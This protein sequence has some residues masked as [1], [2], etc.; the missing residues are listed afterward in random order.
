[1]E[2]EIF[3][4]YCGGHIVRNRLCENPHKHNGHGL[5]KHLQTDVNAH[6]GKETVGI[7][8]LSYAH[9][10]VVEQEY[11]GYGAYHEKQPQNNLRQ[12]A[13]MHSG[14]HEYKGVIPK[15]HT[16]GG[17]YGEHTEGEASEEPYHG[18]NELR[19]NVLTYANRQGEHKIALRAQQILVKSDDYDNEGRHRKSE[20][21]KEIGGGQAEGGK[22]R[23]AA[24]EFLRNKAHRIAQ[25]GNKYEHGI[26]GQKVNRR[27]AKFVFHQFTEHL[28]TSL[29]TPSRDFPLCSRI[30]SQLSKM[31]ISPF[32]RK[33]ASSR[34]FSM[35]LIRWVEMTTTAF[36]S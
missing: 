14:E 19:Q 20:C 3:N 34:M 35:S 22:Y 6:G 12:V 7:E 16:H 18:G 4:P 31:E 13:K 9:T 27:C 26:N 21:Q 28:N 11:H 2:Q 32:L 36:S 25:P 1:M 10:E 30:L 15:A 33:I 29:N 23:V 5:Q 8:N 17:S 24:G